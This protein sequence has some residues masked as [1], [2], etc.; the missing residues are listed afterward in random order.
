[1]TSSAQLMDVS[2]QGMLVLVDDE[3]PQGVSVMIRLIQPTVTAWF[4]ARVAESRAL[5]QG[6][7]Q[8]RLVF[9]NGSPTG[10]VALV[11][12]RHGEMN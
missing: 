12:S 1:M 11:A 8:L 10:F 6:P 2:R 3:P 7:Y 5:R 9:L 4:E